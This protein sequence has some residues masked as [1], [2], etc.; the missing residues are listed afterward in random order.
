MNKR[1]M[2]RLRELVGRLTRAKRKEL[3]GSLT[4]QTPASESV[5]L[6][7]ATARRPAGSFSGPRL[8]SSASCLRARRGANAATASPPKPRAPRAERSTPRH[9]ATADPRSL[10]RPPSADAPAGP[11]RLRQTQPVG[12]GRPPYL[13]IGFI[14]PV[15]QILNNSFWSSPRYFANLRIG[16][17]TLSSS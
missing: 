13:V 16:G 9:R 7:E 17:T 5:E 1:D 10:C 14:G 3:M 2:Q 15:I 4:A 11:A 6:L 8:S 12:L